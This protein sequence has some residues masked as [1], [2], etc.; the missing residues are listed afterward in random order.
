M[1][2]SLRA[3]QMRF[4]DHLRDPAACQPPDGLDERRLE[5]YREL[6][7]ANIEGLLRQTF[8]VLAKVLVDQDKWQPTVRE[9]Y[10]RHRGATP[11]F[12]HIAVE[13]VHWLREEE[14]SLALPPFAAELAHYERAEMEVDF[15]PAEIDGSTLDANGDLLNGS[16]VLAPCHRLLH[17]RWPVTRISVDFQPREPLPEPIHLLLYRD[18]NDRVRFMEIN[19]VT[20]RLLATMAACPSLT[21]TELLAGVSRELP[22]LDPRGVALHGARLLAELHQQEAIIGTRVR[23]G[24]INHH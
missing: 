17:Y 5:I 3:L 7:H 1:T 12:P 23:V 14:A 20:A 11:Y 6:F 13:F 16:P 19:A 18:K 9:F 2:T 4:A 24:Y 21:G 8:P 15:D 10:A 22:H